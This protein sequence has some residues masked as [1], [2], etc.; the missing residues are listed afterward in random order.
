[1]PGPGNNVVFSEDADAALLSNR[2]TTNLG[3][4]EQLSTDAS[5]KIL[6]LLRFNVQNISGPVNNATLRLFAESDSAVG[7]DVAEVAAD[8]WVETAVTYN[9]APA[10]GSTITS[11]GEFDSGTWVEIDITSYI[12][13]PGEYS[14]AISSS[15]GNRLMFSSGEGSNPPELLVSAN[16]GPAPASSNTPAPPTA[17]A[18][19]SPLP[20]NTPT[21]SASA[22]ATPAPTNTPTGRPSPTPRSR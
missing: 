13:G 16:S 3:L 8:S 14:L 11:S 20:T 10:I 22:S 19:P 18:S 15:D 4:A 5:P 12:T 1:M 6:S 9:T 2:P 17:T 21:V 7:V